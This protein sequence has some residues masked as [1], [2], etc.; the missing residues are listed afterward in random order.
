MKK[1]ILIISIIVLAT[2]AYSM[3]LVRFEEF[4]NDQ[5]LEPIAPP[6]GPTGNGFI[7]S[8][9]VYF[10]SQEGYFVSD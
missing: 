7:S 10:V 6:D 4:F 3:D 9:G 5:I 2:F 8:E 1:F